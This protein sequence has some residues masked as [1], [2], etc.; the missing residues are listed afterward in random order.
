LGEIRKYRDFFPG[1]LED[2]LLSL[3]CYACDVVFS[4][5]F[6]SHRWNVNIPPC[7][8]RRKPGLSVLLACT[9]FFDLVLKYFQSSRQPLE[10]GYLGYI[11]LCTV[12][13]VRGDSY[14]FDS[15][16]PTWELFV[17][18][19]IHL[20]S[21]CNIRVISPF[22]VADSS[23]MTSSAREFQDHESPQGSRRQF[24]FLNPQSAGSTAIRIF[25]QQWHDGIP[26]LLRIIESMIESGLSLDAF[27]VY[28]ASYNEGHSLD[29]RPYLWFAITSSD[30]VV[31][32]AKPSYLLRLRL[33]LIA[34]EDP[35]IM[36]LVRRLLERLPET[37]ESEHPI[38]L[39][40]TYSERKKSEMGRVMYLPTVPQAHD[41]ILKWLILGLQDELKR[42][43]VRS[44]NRREVNI[45]KYLDSTINSC[46]AIPLQRFHE[47]LTEEGY[48]ILLEDYWETVPR[49][50]DEDV[51]AEWKQL[52]ADVRKTKFWN[53]LVRHAARPVL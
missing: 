2:E 52:E 35:K 51:E 4:P 13:Y 45:P 34:S 49:P 21:D 44:N 39:A 19:L 10:R 25:C 27:V 36:E 40:F 28:A 15:Y 32:K 3:V 14:G 5:H 20:G 11:T 33:E 24:I 12:S 29:I 16:Y 42:S 23:S 22:D 17:K 26:S 18:E 37:T 38:V 53:P 41:K 8:F 9:K 47:Q 31:F 7:M 48:L 6:A 1:D 46:E 50:S 30:Y 43:G